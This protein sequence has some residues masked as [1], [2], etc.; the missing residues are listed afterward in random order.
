MSPRTYEEELTEYQRSNSAATDDHDLTLSTPTILGLFFALV[1][2]CGC[3]FGLGY[4]MGHRTVPAPQVFDNSTA[5]AIGTAK[6]AAG[7]AAVPDAPAAA[8]PVA[9]PNTSAA[10]TQTATVSLNAAPTASPASVPA[11]APAAYAPAPLAASTNAPVRVIPPPPAS[12]AAAAG[13]FVVQVAAVSSQD[14]ANILI[15]TLQKKGYAV[16]ARHEPQDQLLHIQIGPFP[17]R[18]DAEAMR[19]R[20]IN[21]GFNAIVK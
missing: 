9:A 13:S 3:F 11:P 14:V 1:V 19:Q 10:A 18:K 7:S 4:A 2:V 20:V 16:A 21:D 5:Q 8:D 12:Q 17:D 6:P 15:S